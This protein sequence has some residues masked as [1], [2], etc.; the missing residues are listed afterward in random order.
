[1]ATTLEQVIKTGNVSNL[2]KLLY[3]SQ[4]C[5]ALNFLS[6]SDPPIIH[7]D[8]KPAN[9]FVNGRTCLLGDFGMMQREGDSDVEPG[10][11]RSYRTPE[12]VRHINTGELPT[13]KSDIYQLGLVLYKLFTGINPQQACQQKT[14]DIVLD[15]LPELPESLAPTVSG[16]LAGTPSND[17]NRPPLPEVLLPLFV[18]LAQAEARR[19]TRSSG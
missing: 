13:A 6:K 1:M 18:E 17:T 10:T 19:R 16:P 11:P 4:L 5:A 14:D 12:L 15:S 3:A 7:R 9:V 8:I 2:D